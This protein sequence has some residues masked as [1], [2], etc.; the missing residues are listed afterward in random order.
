[1]SS[2]MTLAFETIL[3]DL[4]R[5][6]WVTQDPLY[7]RYHDE[8]W[9]RPEY[10]PQ[11]LYE[12][13]VLEAFQSGLSWITVLRKRAAFRH[14][15]ANFAPARVAAYG[16]GDIERLLSDPSIIRHRGKIEAAIAGAKAWLRLEATHPGGFSAFVWD[17]V[18][19]A[20]RVNHW[21]SLD[22]VPANTPEAEVLSRRLKKNGFRFVGPTTTYSFMQAAGLVDDHLVT[23]FRRKNS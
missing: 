8:E 23:C 3:D 9:G 1:M 13:L 16:E 14:A 11:R 2:E 4:P 15:F 17:S 10:D 19:G 7:R 6:G 5:C 22:E 18:E 21:R 12:L 20:P